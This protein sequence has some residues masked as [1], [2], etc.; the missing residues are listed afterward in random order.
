M[1]LEGGIDR[2]FANALVK[3]VGWESVVV[4]ETENAPDDAVPVLLI[5][6][7]EVSVS[8][9]RERISAVLDES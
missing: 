1:L 6:P 4:H 5:L 9:L 7:T 8:Q 2:P 3:G